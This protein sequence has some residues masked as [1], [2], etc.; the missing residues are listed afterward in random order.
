MI[1]LW[2]LA[3]VGLIFV[4]FFAVMYWRWTKQ[5]S[6][7]ATATL[8]GGYQQVAEKRWTRHISPVFALLALTSLLV[9]FARPQA[10]VDVPRLR[11]TVVLAFDTSQSMAADDLEPT[12][13]EAAKNAAL[14]FLESQPDSVDIGVVSFGHTGAITLS[15][16]QERD[17]VAA[18]INRLQPV[19]STSLSE[20]VFAALSAIAED[21][22]IYQPDENGNVDIP[23]V[24]FGSFGSSI[25]VLFSDGEDTTEADPLPL[26]DLG[27]QAGI[28]IYPVGVGTLEGT[29]L[30]IDGFSVST[31]L[32][33]ESLVGLA[34]QSNGTY[35]QADDQDDLAAVTETIERDLTVEEERLEISSF[36]A[37]GGLV[38]ITIAAVAS[39]VTQ[40]RLP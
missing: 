17:D 2:P 25:I 18:A 32:N 16:S 7:N 13:L 20:G 36:F 37:G 31:A 3:L 5:R 29:T 38:L 40:R 10:T 15:P 39:M 27:A 22:I 4:P 33:E 9:G 24:D 34:E 23:P 28:R 11:S 35:F 30:D 14:L 21:P 19:G 12:R 8:G 26:A 6:S 1:F